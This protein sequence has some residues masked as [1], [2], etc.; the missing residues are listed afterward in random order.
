M[1]DGFGHVKEATAAAS[2][3]PEDLAGRVARVAECAAALRAEIGKI[4]VGQRAV[5]DEVLTSVFAG[6]HVLLA[7]PPGL[8]RTVLVR[9][10]AGAAGLS[11]RRIQF[12]PDM[13][14]SDVTGADV[15]TEDRA[16]GERGLRF[17]PGPIFANLVLAD[18][19]NRTPPKTQAAL[20]EAMEERCVTVGSRTHPVPEPFLVLATL[21]L[22]DTE[23]VYELPPGSPQLDRF[24][25]KVVT[26][27]PTRAEEDAIL[28]RTT[29]VYRAEV[30]P[31]LEPG[32]LAAHQAT[33]RALPAP[34]NV[35]D[36]ATE[37]ARATRPREPGAPAFVREHVAWGAGVR[38]SQFLVLGAK[39]R[40]AVEGRLC[41]SRGDVRAIAPAALRHRI[42]PNFHAAALSLT[43]DVLV[44]RL[45]EEI[46][47]RARARFPIRGRL[48]RLL[49]GS[50]GGN[51][52]K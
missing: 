23:G 2:A 38:A 22:V 29:G 19:V 28:D 6:G 9:A 26:R 43:P 31:V 24:M 40:A 13:L 5:V 49:R 11:F 37:L 3:V 17:L 36:Y 50:R 30:G 39:A 18:E 33:V 12:T 15:F 1:P 27:Y 48:A 32:A 8:A 20:L 52:G 4:L 41:V 35:K 46:D 51:G 21:N 16:T 45:L 14:P 42:V 7:G 25:L 34:T 47:S 44:G 10:L